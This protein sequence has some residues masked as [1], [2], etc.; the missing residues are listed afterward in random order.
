MAQLDPLPGLPED[1]SAVGLLRVE[2]Q[3]VP[4]ATPNQGPVGNTAPT[5]AA[6]PHPWDE[7]GAAELGVLSQSR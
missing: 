3:Q 7:S 2:E 4:M 5:G 6:G 1:P